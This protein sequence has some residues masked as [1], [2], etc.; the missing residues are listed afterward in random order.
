MGSIAKEMLKCVQKN[1]DYV[2][3]NDQTMYHVYKNVIEALKE[4]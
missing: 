2:F 1:V 3:I 4:Y